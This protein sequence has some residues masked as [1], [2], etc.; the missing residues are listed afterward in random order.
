MSPALPPLPAPPTVTTQQ[1]SGRPTWQKVLFFV[2]LLGAGGGIG[3]A[4]GSLGDTPNA[5]AWDL[6]MGQQIVLWSLLVLGICA[7]LVVHEAGHLVGGKLAGFRFALLIVGPLM[8]VRTAAALQVKLNKSLALYGGLALSVPEDTHD[9]RRRTCW[10]VA[11]GP[12]ASLL[13]GGLALA[14][15]ALAFA[16]LQPGTDGF[17]QKLMG[18]LLLVFG[19]TSCAI[20]LITLI[21]GKTS[22]FLTDGARLLQLRKDTPAAARDAALLGLFAQSMTGT[23]PRDLDAALLAEAHAL[24]DDSVF[25]ASA[26]AWTYARA[27]DA[28]NPASARD[29]LAQQL[30]LWHALPAMLRANL[31]LEATYFEAAHRHDDDAAE[32][33]RAQADESTPFLDPATRHRA[34]AALAARRG[35]VEAFQIACHHAEAALAESLDRGRARAQR[36][37][38]AALQPV[39]FGA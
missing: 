20:G 6:T 30:T 25:E 36:D 22:G 4:L 8:L 21:P 5:P 26:H 29:A 31:A 35:D 15:R 1:A 23:R 9:L 3:F 14:L 33:W 39:D 11:G 7:T 24:H 2:L 37:W 27:L 32:A 12:V 10:V 16:D 28:G 17:G 38:L 19:G 18:D 34:E 13:L